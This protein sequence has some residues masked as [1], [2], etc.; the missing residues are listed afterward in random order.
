MNGSLK[1]VS[2]KKYLSQINKLFY[3][4]NCKTKFKTDCG[5]YSTIAKNLTK[6][7]QNGNLISDFL[8]IVTKFSMKK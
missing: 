3:Q 8:T 6:F 7:P 1:K 2:A 5:Q 4:Q